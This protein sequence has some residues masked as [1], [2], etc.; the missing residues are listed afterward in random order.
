MPNI[1]Q[2]ATQI[3]QNKT[4]NWLWGFGAL[5]LWGFGAS[6]PVESKS[7]GQSLF[8]QFCEMR[9]VVLL[10]L[11]YEARVDWNET[12]HFLLPKL[13]LGQQQA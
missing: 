8:N 2:Q 1:S 6:Q 11:P 13:Q 4:V 10:A 3:V 9:Q 12:K 7:L 5:G